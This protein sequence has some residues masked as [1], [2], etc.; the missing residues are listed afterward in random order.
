MCSGAQFG[1]HMFPVLASVS[2][3]Q[4]RKLLRDF[5]VCNEAVRCCIRGCVCE[6]RVSWERVSALFWQLCL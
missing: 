5:A 1:L 3:Q 2:F 4:E 6:Q